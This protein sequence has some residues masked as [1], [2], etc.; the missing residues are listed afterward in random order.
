MVEVSG[1]GEASLV[2]AR[3]VS[4]LVNALRLEALE[5]CEVGER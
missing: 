5:P 3:G 1:G 2:M 4:R